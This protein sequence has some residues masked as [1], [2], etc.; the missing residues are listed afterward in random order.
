MRGMAAKVVMILHLLLCKIDH[1]FQRCYCF[2]T[3]CAPNCDGF[4]KSMIP[5]VLTLVPK[6]SLTFDK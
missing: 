1:D 3:R 5:K 2:F 6:A 4:E